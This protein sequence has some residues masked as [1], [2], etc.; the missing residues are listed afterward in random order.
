[1]GSGDQDEVEKVDTADVVWNELRRLRDDIP[2]PL[3]DGYPDDRACDAFHKADQAVAALCA[4]PREEMLGGFSKLVEGERLSDLLATLAGSTD[5]PA[6]Q[7]ACLMVMCGVAGLNRAHDAICSRPD[8]L[9]TLFSI[10]AKPKQYRISSIGAEEEL[11][12]NPAVGAIICLNSLLVSCGGLKAEDVTVWEELGALCAIASALEGHAAFLGGGD[13]DVLPAMLFG[14]A[15]PL[16]RAH[17]PSDLLED[18]LRLSTAFLVL[19]ADRREWVA[20]SLA[21][22]ANTTQADPAGLAGQP[23]PVTVDNLLVS[24]LSLPGLFGAACQKTSVRLRARAV[25]AARECERE[26]SYSP[27]FAEALARCLGLGGQ[28]AVRRAAQAALNEV[29]AKHPHVLCSNPGCGET[30]DQYATGGLFK[31]CARCQSSLYCSGECQV[32][33]WKNGHKTACGGKA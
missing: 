16:L 9:K 14:L 6:L 31:R 26:G 32:A 1:M 12:V 13:E 25:A 3:E 23:Q 29:R 8:I 15:T 2:P 4:I 22:A 19:V 10:L 33:H 24:S 27:G 5:H 21:M 18:R 20:R 28:K 11:E 7:H 17:Q 30:Q